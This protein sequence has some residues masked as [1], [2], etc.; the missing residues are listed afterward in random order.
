MHDPGLQP[1]RTL[2]SIERTLFS[3]LIVI[4]TLFKVFINAPAVFHYLSFFVFLAITT[5]YI[6]IL[7]DF[8]NLISLKPRSTF[9]HRILLLSSSIF[10]IILAIFSINIIYL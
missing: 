4:F 6:F 8:K 3:Y 10:T 2:L 1:E 7:L 5:Y 9:L